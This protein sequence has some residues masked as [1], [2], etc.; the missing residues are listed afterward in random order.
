MQTASRS[1]TLLTGALILAMLPLGVAETQAQLQGDLAAPEDTADSTVSARDSSERRAAA[2][3]RKVGEGSPLQ[4]DSPPPVR[5]TLAAR[6]PLGAS[7]TERP[8]G[9]SRPFGPA[10]GQAAGFWFV[11]GFQ[12]APDHS[13]GSRAGQRP[14]LRPDRLSPGQ[15]LLW[16]AAGLT[17]TLFTESEPTGLQA[18]G[19][20]A[21]GPQATGRRR[22][23]YRLAPPQ[24]LHEARRLHKTSPVPSCYAC[25]P[26]KRRSMRALVEGLF[27][28]GSHTELK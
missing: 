9:F 18:I 10:R 5:R 12:A 11:R 2:A 6:Q 26:V 17:L 23:P 15:N 22:A 24:R 4:L 1:L 21:I 28:L 14:P 8:L 3:E 27:N 7:L 13:R 16:A 19:P 20:Q 25:D